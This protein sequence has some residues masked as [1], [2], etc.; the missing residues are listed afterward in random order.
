MCNYSRKYC[1]VEVNRVFLN[2][3]VKLILFFE[4]SDRVGYRIV[5]GRVDFDFSK[6]F[7]IGLFD[8]YRRF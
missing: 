1:F 8:L 4:M 6:I 2:S 7:G 5:L 3:R